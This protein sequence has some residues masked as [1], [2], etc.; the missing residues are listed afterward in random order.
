MKAEKKI[1]EKST[2]K[3]YQCY[4]TI[5]VNHKRRRNRQGGGGGGSNKNVTYY[6]IRIIKPCNSA[7][8]RKVLSLTQ[9]KY[10]FSEVKKLWPICDNSYSKIQ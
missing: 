2:R 9:L 5:D 8:V 6:Q 3:L 10:T 7:A 1:K 4:K